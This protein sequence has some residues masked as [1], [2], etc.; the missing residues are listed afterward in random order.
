LTLNT[1]VGIAEL[2]E[3]AVDEAEV[4]EK[5]DVSWVESVDWAGLFSD[6]GERSS[7]P[8]NF[9]LDGD[10]HFLAGVLGSIVPA[11]P[12]GLL[13]LLDVARTLW[14]RRATLSGATTRLGALASLTH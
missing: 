2:L 6:E 13:G 1:E 3:V 8:L 10:I 12:G 4:R 5:A 11:L 9:I 7:P 14:G